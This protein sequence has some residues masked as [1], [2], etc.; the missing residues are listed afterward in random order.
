[1]SRKQYFLV[2]TVLAVAGALFTAFLTSELQA[3]KERRNGL[4]NFQLHS[5][6]P[7][8]DIIGDFAFMDAQKSLF[9]NTELE[10]KVWVADFIFTNC[11]GICPIMT[12]NMARIQKAFVERSDVN[13]VSFS[14]DPENDTPEVLNAYGKRYGANPERWHAASRLHDPG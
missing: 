6:L 4:A 7:V 5:G 11:A 12:S 10:G 8:L 9:Q 14:V 2:S 13:F 1:M 3:R